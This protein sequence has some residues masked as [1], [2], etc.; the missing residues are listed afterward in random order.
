[1]SN[2][3]NL[4]AC[5]KVLHTSPEG[6]RRHSESLGEVYGQE[7]NIYP[8]KQCSEVYNTDIFHVGYGF[9]AE[10]LSKKARRKRKQSRGRKKR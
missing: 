1:M 7:P 6:A 3:Q 10:K 4:V 5:G 8:C 2:T 9:D